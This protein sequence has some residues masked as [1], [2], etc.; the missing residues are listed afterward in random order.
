MLNIQ[1]FVC[2]P[3]Q[4]NT[5]VVSDETREAVII[6][7]GAWSDVERQAIRQYIADEG[8]TPVHLLATHGH[9][10]HNIGNRFVQDEWG[11]RVEIHS[12]D[13]S[14]ISSL[15]KQAAG[16]WGITLP[17]EQLAPVGRYLSETD[18]IRFGSHE[19]GI[20]ETPGH[21][22]G[23]VF[24]YCKDEA[25]TFSGDTLFRGSI[26]RCDF[27]GGSMFLI[28]QSLRMICQ[29]PDDVKVYPGHGE[30]TTIG[31]E[32]ETNPYIDR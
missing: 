18:I 26:G 14:L 24:Y 11:L 22:P 31:Y 23:G 8:L 10:D 29:L 16:M 6:D 17:P 13:E 2:N 30:A 12:G 5:Y 19:L 20:L 21:S 9:L 25:V 7:C 4:E 32:S 27:E 1:R 15:P 3:L 28:I